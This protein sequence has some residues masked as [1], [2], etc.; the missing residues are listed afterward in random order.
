MEL[1]LRQLVRMQKF[2]FGTL[3]RVGE[4]IWGRILPRDY[5]QRRDRLSHPGVCVSNSPGGIH[6]VVPMIFGSHS[7][8]EGAFATHL[9]TPPEKLTYFG[10]F[11]PV[12]IERDLFVKMDHYLFVEEN[13]RQK[14][15]SR[16]D[17][18]RF[19]REL[20][21]YKKNHVVRFQERQILDPEQ[22]RSLEHY[23]KRK[24]LQEKG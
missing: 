4:N 19:E 8:C 9:D 7:K 18:D 3:W 24:F 16:N 11:A 5:V 23:L 6:V 2:A 17:R 1:S 14:S 10:A 22:I 20:D 15:R 12:A 13:L 21:E